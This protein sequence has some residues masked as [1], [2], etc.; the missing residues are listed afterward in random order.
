M[1][2]TDLGDSSIA[3]ID[4]CRSSDLSGVA[5]ICTTAILDSDEH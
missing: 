3:V 5:N 4:A 2:C 1:A